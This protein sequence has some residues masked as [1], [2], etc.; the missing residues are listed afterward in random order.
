MKKIKEIARL[1]ALGLS[2]RQIA[3]SLNISKGVVHKYLSK[4]EDSGLQWP[5]QDDEHSL[6]KTLVS[7]KV[8]FVEPDYAFIYQEL[9]I[10]GVTLLLLHEEYQR[11]YPDQHY[12]YT[13]FCCLYRRWKKTQKLS[14]K[15]LHKGGDKLFIDYAGPKVTIVDSQTGT[16]QQASLFIAVMG[17]SQYTFAEATWDQSL[18]NWLGSHVR[19][20]QYLGGVPALLVPDNLKAGVSQ[21]CAYDPDIN[22][23]YAELAAHY[24][25]AVMPARPYKPKDKAKVENGV[26]LVERW[27]LARLRHQTF[28]SL[29]QINQEIQRLLMHLNSK[30]FQKMPGSR[31]SV[32]EQLDHPA[33]KPLPLK[34]Y[35]YA[36][37]KRLRVGPDYHLEIDQHFY[38]VPYSYVG[39]TVDVRLS[40]HVVEIYFKGVRI[41]SHERKKTQGM[42]TVNLHQPSSHRQHQEWSIEAALNW[43]LNIGPATHQLLTLLYEQKKHDHQKYRL[44]LGFAKLAR[45][46]SEKRLEQACHRANCLGLYSYKRIA[47]SL[48]NKLDQE[49]LPVSEP[50]EM[51]PIAHANIRGSSYYG[52]NQHAH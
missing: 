46:F 23:A 7:Q 16:S 35:T 30:A 50:L 1:K 40:A 36:S 49:Q 24:N 25:T 44:F 3:R 27:I 11:T 31:L 19:A 39:E 13:Q 47:Q 33:L 38:S 18:E 37:F 10:K 42:T 52:E 20:F 14:L 26:L 17:A 4:L 8:K 28:Y 29:S 48:K 34:P 12:S 5:L 21:A 9:K 2:Q 45:Y 41:A 6:Q 32:F 22:P 51:P 43:S 15:Q